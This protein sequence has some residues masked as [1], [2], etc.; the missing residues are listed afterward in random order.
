LWIPHIAN[1]NEKLLLI[2]YRRQSTRS[3]R[4][5]KRNQNAVLID[6]CDEDAAINV[7]T[8]D[9]AE[10]LEGTLTYMSLLFTHAVDLA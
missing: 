5:S 3:R 1:E 8:I 7:K 4:T 10:K 9:I 2:S 6:D